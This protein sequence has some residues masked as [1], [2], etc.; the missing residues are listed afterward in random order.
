M[1]WVAF[2]TPAIGHFHDDGLYLVTARALVEG[3]GYRIDSLPS[4]L[5][6]TKYPV[7]YPAILAGLWRLYPEFPANVVVFKLLSLLCTIGWGI[8]LFRLFREEGEDC[9]TCWWILFFTALSG[10]VAFLSSSVLPDT[11]YCLFTALGILLAQRVAEGR[12]A[13]P[14][15]AIFV[16]AVCGSCAML[17]RTVGVAFLGAAVLVLLLRRHV[18]LGVIFAA[19]CSALC[20]PWIAWQLRQPLPSDL[21][22][23][24]YSRLCYVGGTIL[25][26]HPPSEAIQG[27]LT[28]TAFLLY[29]FPSM[30]SL[31]T[32]WFTGIVGVLI[33]LLSL[34]GLIVAL[35]RRTTV[36]H[37]WFLFSIGIL[38]CWLW[39]P[40]RYFVPLLPVALWL[41]VAPLRA[42]LRATPRWMPARHAALVALAVVACV[43][44]FSLTAAARTMAETGLPAIGLMVPDEWS[45]TLA[46]IDW[47]KHKTPIGSVIAANLDP[48]YYLLAG[49]KAIRLWRYDAYPLIYDGETERCPL[50]ELEEMRTSLLRHKVDYVVLTPATIFTESTHYFRHFIRMQRLRPGAFEPAARLPDC[51]YSIYRVDRS[52]LQGPPIIE[53]DHMKLDK[54]GMSGWVTNPPPIARAV[55]ELIR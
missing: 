2:H 54:S 22:E 11:M 12:S 36:I 52:R 42:M 37:L 13:H 35:R 23:A 14:Q 34:A 31:P 41:S 45:K 21:I 38:L 1:Y 3:N 33:A 39:P 16:A 7:L 55:P 24:Y 8:A 26:G 53:T 46:L 17:I 4:E 6:Q 10:Y 15:A 40:Q 5:P 32:D 28:N 18:R 49:R 19:T 20:L 50:G 25:S 51:R 44:L 29:I 27:F 30:Y 47:V 9:V 48:Q 43:S